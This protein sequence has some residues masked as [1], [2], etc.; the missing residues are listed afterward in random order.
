MKYKY[1][2]QLAYKYKL[3]VAK[4]RKMKFEKLIYII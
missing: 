2:L 1:M 3:L 4:L